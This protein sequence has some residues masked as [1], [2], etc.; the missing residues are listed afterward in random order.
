MFFRKPPT[1][2][3]LVRQKHIVFSQSFTVKCFDCVT[4]SSRTN[5]DVP[6][7]DLSE[8]EEAAGDSGSQPV[9]A[10][11]EQLESGQGESGGRSSK[12]SSLFSLFQP[13]SGAVL[14]SSPSQPA[15]KAATTATTATTATRNDSSPP[16]AAADSNATGWAVFD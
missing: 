3:T 7:L 12:R 8:F 6:P 9:H 5:F 13:P 4:D 10:P 11:S 1:V 16:S 15:G 2:I 14:S